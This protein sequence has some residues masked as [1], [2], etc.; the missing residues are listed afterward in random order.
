MIDDKEIEVE[1][2][3]EVVDEATEVA[4]DVD[5]IAKFLELAVPGCLAIILA[6]ILIA[7]LVWFLM[8]ELFIRLDRIDQRL[9]RYE[10]QRTS[11]LP[12]EHKIATGALLL[13]TD[14]TKK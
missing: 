13:P 2:Q 3:D 7:G 10:I 5:G 1:V 6:T 9:E 4:L 11:G 12:I 14:K 8:Q